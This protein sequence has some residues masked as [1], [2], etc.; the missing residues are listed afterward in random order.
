MYRHLMVPLDDSPLSA[1][2]VRQ[3]VAL[4]K[5]LDARITFFHA[6]EDATTSVTALEGVML[7][8]LADAPD[9][10]SGAVLAEAADIA[11]ESGVEHASL[12]T[13][14]DRPYEAILRAA[15]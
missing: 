3:S 14:S 10:E 6:N 4:A 7:S 8:T 9:S 2:I 13:V 11:Q 15:K 5:R 1:E 12:S